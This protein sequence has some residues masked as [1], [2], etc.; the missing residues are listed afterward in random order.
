MDEHT[1]GKGAKLGCLNS[2][3]NPV[4][5]LGNTKGL[6]RSDY[7][8]YIYFGSICN[9]KISKTRCHYKVTRDECI[10]GYH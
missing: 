5:L 6:I 9:R 2:Q 1:K 8:L 10:P 4:N 3:K 7:K